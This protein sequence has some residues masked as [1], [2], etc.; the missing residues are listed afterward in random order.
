MLEKFGT[1]WGR[2]EFEGFHYDVTSVEPKLS[3]TNVFT[4]KR[5]ADDTVHLYPT[6]G[7]MKQ[8]NKQAKFNCSLVTL[9]KNIET[10]KLQ[11]VSEVETDVTIKLITR[12]IL[13]CFTLTKHSVYCY[14]PKIPEAAPQKRKSR[15]VPV[16][17]IAI[18]V[19][20]V[21]RVL[22]FD[23]EE[24]VPMELKILCCDSCDAREGVQTISVPVD[25]VATGAGD[26]DDVHDRID[27]CPKCMKKLVI[28]LLTKHVENVE[29]PKLF[30]KLR[31][32]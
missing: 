23:D 9:A 21:T 30:K 3:S 8:L 16:K 6:K 10:I 18:P 29:I 13:I 24:K 32:K 5:Y 7:F 31:R 12:G 4:I 1:D 27:Q 2:L 17:S 19:K 14:D 11:F 22:N 20:R 25:R 28:N 26:M 15:V